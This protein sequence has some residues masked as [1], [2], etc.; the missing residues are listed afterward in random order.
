MARSLVKRGGCDSD[1]FV[2]FSQCALQRLA[3]GDPLATLGTAMR[4]GYPLQRRRDEWIARPGRR[5]AK[6]HLLAG[7]VGAIGHRFTQ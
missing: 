4:A 2:F 7:L 3:I 1:V 5:N 6:R